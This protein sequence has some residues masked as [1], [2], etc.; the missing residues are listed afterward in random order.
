NGLGLAESLATAV[1]GYI[2]PVRYPPH[3]NLACSLKGVVQIANALPGSRLFYLTYGGFDTHSNQVLVHA[4]LWRDVSEA[5]AAFYEDLKEHELE[6][7]VVLF[8]WSEF[9]RRVRENGSGTD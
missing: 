3:N 2:S 6:E 1:A 5:I 7:R 9:G 4:R 8:V